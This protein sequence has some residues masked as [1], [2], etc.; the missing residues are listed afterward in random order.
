[1]TVTAIILIAC[2]VLVVIV[3]VTMFFSYNNR[4]IALRKEA[5]AQRN[6]VKAV[7]DKMF[8]IIQEKA[9]VATEYRDSFE[10]IFPDLIGGRYSNGGNDMMRWIQEQNPEFDTSLYSSLMQSI[11]VQR[12]SF[13]TAQTR[14]LDI[15]NMRAALI[16][17]YPSR[18][19]ISNKQP[20]E[21]EVIAST[22]TSNVMA[23]GI[24]DEV[25]TF[26]K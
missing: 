24:D 8:K 26:K 17:Q 1:M 21:Y 5:E 4:E 2:A 22:H 7:H 9:N 12:E 13:N 11:E 23:T 15:I 25:L 3:G 19:F 6:K 18:W 14:M 16:E 10:K 20:I